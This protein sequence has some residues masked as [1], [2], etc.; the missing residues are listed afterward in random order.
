MNEIVVYFSLNSV[1][2]ASFYQYIKA[3]RIC[4]GP[5]FSFSLEGEDVAFNDPR[6]LITIIE[7]NSKKDSLHIIC[8]YIFF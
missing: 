7:H 8:C 3:N 2:K 5:K 6:D 4:Y 1:R